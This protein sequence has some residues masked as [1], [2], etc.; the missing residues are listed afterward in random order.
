MWVS[1][2]SRVDGADTFLYSPNCNSGD[3][4]ATLDSQNAAWGKYRGYF[5]R[6]EGERN[7]V[8][9][10]T[11][12][13]IIDISNSHLFGSLDGWSRSNITV[14]KVL[15]VETLTQRQD[16]VEPDSQSAGLEIRRI[17]RF[18]SGLLSF[19][20]SLFGP[21]TDP[22]RSILADGFLI[23]D[24][25]GL[26]ITRDEFLRRTNPFIKASG[27]N[28]GVSRRVTEASKTSLTAIGT[29]DFVNSHPRVR[30]NC[31]VNFILVDGEWLIRGASIRKI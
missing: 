30:Y 19:L 9:R 13:G 4:F 16:L 24:E 20:Q 21:S 25:N 5:N 31:E 18:R 27:S 26:S 29:I 7:H 8:L 1:T 12:D 28:I 22:I 17:E 15:A 23:S 14:S 3:Y 6:L 2:V 10:I 11:F